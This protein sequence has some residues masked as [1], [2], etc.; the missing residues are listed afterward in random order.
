MC[1]CVCSNIYYYRAWLMGSVA[2]VI[3]DVKPAK[4]IVDEMVVEAA[5]RLRTASTFLVV[6]SSKL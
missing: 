1:V 3:N 4:E 6:P 2:A 5:R